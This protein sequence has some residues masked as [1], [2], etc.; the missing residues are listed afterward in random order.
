MRSNSQM[1]TRSANVYISCAYGTL[2]VSVHRVL[3][4]FSLATTRRQNLVHNKTALC[5][6]TSRSLIASA[7]QSMLFCLNLAESAIFRLTDRALATSQISGTPADVAKR[8]T[9]PNAQQIDSSTN[10]P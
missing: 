3:C 5:S 6:R 1:R 8:K 10:V 9:A 4:A 7:I 2:C